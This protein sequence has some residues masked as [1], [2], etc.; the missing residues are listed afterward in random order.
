MDRSRLARL[1]VLSIA[2]ALVTIGLKA[3]AYAVTG[4]VGLLSD[5]LESVVNLVAAVIAFITLRYATRPPDAD[6]AFGH[7][8]A[9]YFSSATEGLLIFVAALGIILASLPRVLNPQPLEQVGIGLAITLAASFVNLITARILLRA[10][11]A[12]A[13]ITLEADARHLLTDVWTS[14]GVLV[15]VAAVGATGWLWLDPLIAIAVALNILWTAFNLVRRSAAGLLDTALPS[16]EQALIETI[17]KRHSADGVYSHALLTRQSGSRRFISMHL[18]VPSHWTVSH[19]H[20]MSEQ[21]E[22]EIRAALP[23][24]NVLTHIEPLDEPVSFEDIT[25]DRVPA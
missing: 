10:A 13:S 4:S 8:K 16:A 1:A 22:A 24:A 15:G 14:V 25:L 6:H 19:G 9:E 2:A 21:I 18:L 7:D 17:L 23:H 5:A 20:A 3:G 11:R 12:H